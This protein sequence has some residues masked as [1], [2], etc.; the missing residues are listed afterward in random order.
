MQVA[1]HKRPSLWGACHQFVINLHGYLFEIGMVGW[2]RMKHHIHFGPQY[3]NSHTVPREPPTVG[4]WDKW[5]TGTP[6]HMPSRE[7]NPGHWCRSPNACLC[8]NHSPEMG[9]MLTCDL[10]GGYFLPHPSHF[11]VISP[12]VTYIS[13]PNFNILQAINLTH[14][15]KRK[16]R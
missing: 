3:W 5:G 16:T 1:E 2:L 12:Q 14:P 15:D 11:S 6:A 4:N 13:S 10:Q 8:A 9:M 7:S